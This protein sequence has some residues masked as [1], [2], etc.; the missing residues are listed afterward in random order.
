MAKVLRHLKKL[1]AEPGRRRVVTPFD[2][3]GLDF[4]NRVAPAL[5]DLESEGYIEG[6]ITAEEAYPLVVTA[7]TGRGRAWPSLSGPTAVY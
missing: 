4:A 5:Q 2:V 3:P 1:L 7:V 6:T